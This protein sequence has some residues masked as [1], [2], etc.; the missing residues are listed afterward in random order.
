MES[1][2]QEGSIGENEMKTES[3]NAAPEKEQANEEGGEVEEQQQEVVLV[4]RMPK[5]GT[6]FG[7]LHE[8]NVTFCID[9]SGSMIDCLKSVKEHVIEFLNQRAVEEVETKF[10]LI[11]FSTKVTQWSDKMVKCT[12]QTVAVASDWIRTLASQTGTNTLEALLTAFSDASTEAVCLI[13]DS[14]PDQNPTDLL[15]SVI[16]AAQNRPVHCFFIHTGTPESVVTEFLQTL[17][18]ETYGSFH[19]ITATDAGLVERITPIYRADATAERVIRTTDGNIYPSNHKICT[20]ATR[21]G[22]IAHVPPGPATILVHK[23]LHPFYLYPWPYRYYYHHYFP[24]PYPSV[25]WSQYRPA[26]AL[27]SHEQDFYDSMINVCPGAGALVVGTK[28]L[29]RRHA[30]GLFYLGKVKSQVSSLQ[31]S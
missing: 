11:E 14:L 29:A 1:V 19:I 7:R 2:N 8:R 10:N 9:T 20:V 15:D 6:M 27:L 13:T 31:V 4:Q 22:D 28:V 18:M 17:G 21:L 24:Y 26:R 5:H 12:P 16:Y 3:E 25:G 30:D 23:N